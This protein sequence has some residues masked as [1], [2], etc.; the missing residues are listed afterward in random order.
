[1]KKKIE[2]VFIELR[3]EHGLVVLGLSTD[4]VLQQRMSIY[5]P[6]HALSFNVRKLLPSVV[7]YYLDLRLC[8]H[9]IFLWSCSGAKCARLNSIKK[10]KV[11]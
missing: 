8:A 11:S 4:I 10:R 5:K 9:V 7:I 6:Q 3:L 1:M 2:K